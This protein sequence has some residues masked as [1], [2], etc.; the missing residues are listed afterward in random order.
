VAWRGPK[1]TSFESSS[2]E[3]NLESAKNQPLVPEHREVR[4]GKGA[5][6]RCIRHPALRFRFPFGPVRAAKTLEREGWNHT[7]EASPL[8]AGVWRKR[9][10]Q[11][12]LGQVCR[13]EKSL[14]VRR[15]I[16]SGIEP[17]P[18]TD[19]SF[20]DSARSYDRGAIPN[21]NVFV[22][23]AW[24]VARVNQ[25]RDCMDAND[26]ERRLSMC[27]CQETSDADR[28]LWRSWWRALRMRFFAATARRGLC[29]CIANVW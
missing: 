4:D 26:C 9:G 11:M 17:R 1:R 14:T 7:L 12:L 29:E 27:A 3:R 5:K 20:G 24:D 19:V 18:Y 2:R 23:S 10:N 8:S 16:R 13:C 15:R 25:I 22:V 28:C 21:L 6:L